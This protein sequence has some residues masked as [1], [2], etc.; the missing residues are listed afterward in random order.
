MIRFLGLRNRSALDPQVATARFY[1]RDESFIES[2]VL[3][4]DQPGLGLILI[5]YTLNTAGDG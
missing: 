4:A 3:F 2:A 1:L 5:R